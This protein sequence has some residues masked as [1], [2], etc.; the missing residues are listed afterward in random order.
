[1][2]SPWNRP[3][4]GLW[5]CVVLVWSAIAWGQDG[6]PPTPDNHPVV[7][8]SIQG[9]VSLEQSFEVVGAD[10]PAELQA[11]VGSHLVLTLRVTRP[12]DT[13]VTLPSNQE[14]GRFELI[15]VDRETP[16][17]P[18]N[19]AASV[20]EV[21]K[22]TYAVYRPGRHVLEPFSLSVLNAEG[23]VKKLETKPVEVRIKSVVANV[24]DPSMPGYRAPVTV[25]YENWVLVWILGVGAGLVFAFGVGALAYRAL[26]P[27]EPPPPPPP[28]RPAHEVALEKLLSI[29]KDN[30]IA[31]GEYEAFYV[32]TSG[33][34][35]EYLGRRYNLSLTD[36]AGLELT[37]GELVSSLHEVKWPRGFDGRVVESF[38]YD[39][40]IVKFAR[41]APTEEEAAKLLQ[42]AF[43]I[44]ERTQATV[45]GAQ[46]LS[47]DPVTKEGSHV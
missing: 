31:E 12:W 9:E 42:E 44:V 25:W 35:R 34:I 13:S 23:G 36:K 38:L 41:Y 5:V 28:P 2:I 37:T 19:A 40:D 1:M 21:L 20:T 29:Q 8:P 45:L 43:S 10:N 47:S 26:K 4:F 16:T 14:T 22:I 39:C 15:R 27:E 32:R 30:L 6:T 3:L 46:T 18:G 24:K 7:S 11:T 17:D 33:A